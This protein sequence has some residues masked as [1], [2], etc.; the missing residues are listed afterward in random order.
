MSDLPAEPVALVTGARKGIGRFLAKH[1]VDQHYRV[2]GCSRQPSDL[3][4]PGY[5]HALADV[6]SEE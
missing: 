5:E 2:I 6:T 3:A 1:L 4:I